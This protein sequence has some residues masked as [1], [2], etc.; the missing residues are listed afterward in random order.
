MV[1]EFQDINDTQIALVRLLTDPDGSGTARPHRF[2]VGDAKQSIYR[3]RGSNVAHFSQFEAELRS[4]GGALHALTQSFRT[5]D[6][7]VSVSNA[8]FRPLFASGGNGSGV[9]MQR[10]S[11]RGPAGREGPHLT[12][13]T[14]KSR[15]ET[16]QPAPWSAAAWRRTRWRPRLPAC[17]AA[18]RQCAIP[19]R[20]ANGRQPPRRRGPVAAAG[21]RARLR[22]GPQRA[23]ACPT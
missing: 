15:V 3:F 21:L 11:G 23:T 10:M 8:L 16:A 6:E 2:L 1:D 9:R 22:A 13:I 18:A 17:C 5:H 7:L 19:K 20:G 4:S 12:V 14:L